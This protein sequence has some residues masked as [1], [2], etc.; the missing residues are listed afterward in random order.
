MSNE[1]TLTGFLRFESLDLGPIHFPDKDRQPLVVPADA[2]GKRYIRSSFLA[3]AAYTV[4]PKPSGV[5][6]IGWFMAYNPDAAESAL[7]R[8]N[9][10]S[11]AVEVPP[12][13]FAGPFQW[14]AGVSAPEAQRF[15]TADVTI[16]YIM[17]ER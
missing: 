15:G 3:G 9:S 7:V 11:A 13:G 6:D 12:G 2:I 5:T 4:L 8:P 17:I 14:E 16:D 1:L 10:A